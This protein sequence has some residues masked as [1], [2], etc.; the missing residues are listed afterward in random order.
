MSDMQAEVQEALKA[1]LAEIGEEYDEHQKKANNALK[2][3]EETNKNSLAMQEE[4]VQMREE[5]NKNI[6]TA[7][8]ESK[9][10]LK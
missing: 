8:T 10:N 7:I 6:S 9:N 3:G 1:R 4:T 5:Q 2:D